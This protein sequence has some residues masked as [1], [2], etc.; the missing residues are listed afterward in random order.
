MKK[1][2]IVSDLTLISLFYVALGVILLGW[3]EL[4]SRII[5]Y[6]FGG[7][8]AAS[9]IL[10]IVRYVLR[11]QYDGMIRRDL[12]VG[13]VLAAAGLFL[14]L[15]PDTVV[16]LLPFVF[17]LLLVAGCAGK[18]QTA[19]D[20]RRVGMQLWYIPLIMGGVSLVLG[21]ILL[22]QPFGSAMVLTRFIG[23]AIIVEGA[24]NLAA[25]PI[26]DRKLQDHYSDRL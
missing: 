10:R 2:R 23:V 8:L 24:E 3:P 16:S 26:F 4:S 11:D 21:V 14:I 12:S 18:I 22:C 17:G 15:R 20:L 7:V 9:G 5:C 19:I 6:A 1:N 13:L 25:L